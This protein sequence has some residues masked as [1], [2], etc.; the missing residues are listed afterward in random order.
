[1]HSDS[2]QNFSHADI[3][4]IIENGVQL[5]GM[6][7]MTSPHHEPAAES[8]KLDAYI[9]SLRTPDRNQKAAEANT[10]ASAHYTGSQACQKCHLDVY[11]LE[12]D[13]DGERGPR[14]A[15]APGCDHTRSQQK[16]CL[17]VHERASGSCR[18]Y[19]WLIER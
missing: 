18:L 12:E 14:S 13:A 5:T 7:A 9:R 19:A 11:E 2:T 15:R 1:L 6:P 16:Q 10:L 3:H 17:E 4:Y 8:W